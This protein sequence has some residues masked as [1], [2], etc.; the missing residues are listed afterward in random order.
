MKKN[1]FN[2]IILTIFCLSTLWS[3]SENI[4][5]QETESDQLSP[6]TKSMGGEY[7]VLGYGYDITGDYLANSSIKSVVVDIAEYHKN[8]YPLAYRSEF[9]GEINNVSYFGQDFI[10]YTKS[11][12]KKS[13]YN[14]SVASQ[15]KEPS[16]K[17]NVIPYTFSAGYTKEESNTDGIS[18]RYS[19]GKVDVIKKHKKHLLPDASPND[20]TQYLTI[21]FKNDLNN[22]SPEAL[23]NKYGTHVLLEFT[24]GGSLSSYFT[25]EI[26]KN[27]VSM[28]K[29]EMIEGLA[30][31]SLAKV[32]LDFNTNQ[33]T[34]TSEQYTKEQN[35]WEMNLYTR[36]G[37]TNGHTITITSNTNNIVQTIN[38]DSWARTVD[39]Q[40]CV[41]VDIN[42]NRTFPL[43]DFVTDPSKKEKIK[44]A[45][46]KYIM[47]KEVDIIKVKPMHQLKSNRSG[48]T[49]WVFSQDEVN[50]AINTWGEQY[51][52]VVG[53]ILAEEQPNTKPMYRLKSKKTGD[54]WYAFSKADADYAVAKWGETLFG[55]DG[56]IYTSQKPDTKPMYRMKSRK[57]GD[58]WYAFDWKDVEYAQAT[59]GD[60]YSGL[61]GYI[62]K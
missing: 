20:L 45:V 1:I 29:T 12:I 17:P 49:W 22:I 18:N 46:E 39:D 51:H 13:L 3:C 8:T 32:G 38:V 30:K 43:Y 33:S 57:S 59:W 56:Y 55:L 9:I 41:L 35:K 7:Q 4:I 11:I 36:G 44:L 42:F 26:V 2:S 6:K 40:H 60:T 61:D 10:E 21:G 34:T 5:N 28:S 52:G 27:T 53:F 16:D 15:T 58:T 47:S 25:S 31:F 19:Y 62:L 50:Y 48:D 23:I 24:V 37:S 14:G 54:T